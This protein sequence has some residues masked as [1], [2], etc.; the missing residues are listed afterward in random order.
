MVLM[1]SILIRIMGI[2]EIT[3]ESEELAGIMLAILL[4]LGNVTFLALDRL[5]T[6][7]EIRL[8]RKRK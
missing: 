1:Y 8:R 5:L 2:T 4:I 6:I 7:L 3:G